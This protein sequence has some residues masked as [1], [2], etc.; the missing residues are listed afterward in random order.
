MTA[1]VSA[2]A[3][4]LLFMRGDFIGLVRGVHF[5]FVAFFAILPT[6]EATLLH[7]TDPRE[8]QAQGVKISAQKLRT[9]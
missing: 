7:Q 2:L 1:P 6:F 5:C 8:V 3:N 9:C 4:P